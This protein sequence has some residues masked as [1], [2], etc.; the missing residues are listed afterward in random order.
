ML[1]RKNK[2]PLITALVL[3]TAL[4]ISW[5]AV[6]N[7]PEK[8]P[9]GLEPLNQ[10]VSNPELSTV[11]QT[12]EAPTASEPPEE[13]TAPAETTEPAPQPKPVEDDPDPIESTDPPPPATSP[14]PLSA[15]FDQDQEGQLVITTGVALEQIGVSADDPDSCQNFDLYQL[16]RV[17]PA[18]KLILALTPDQTWLCLAARDDGGQVSLTSYRVLPLTGLLKPGFVIRQTDDQ[19]LIEALDSETVDDYHYIITDNANCHGLLFRNNSG[20][21]IAEE[22][23]LTEADKNRHYCIRGQDEAG[24]HHY[25]HRYVNDHDDPDLAHLAQ[26]LQLTALGE[27]IFWAANPKLFHDPETFAATCSDRSSGCYIGRLYIRGPEIGLD[28]LDYG[29]FE[30]VGAHELSHAIWRQHLTAE[31]QQKIRQL[32]EDS[33]GHEEVFRN[34]YRFGEEYDSFIYDRITSETH[35]TVIQKAVELPTELDD[36]YRQFFKDP[37][38]IRNFDRLTKNRAEGLLTK[39]KRD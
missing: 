20:R 38:I 2:Y 9:A 37:L 35:S 31:G 13:Q 7:Q 1:A 11:D 28:D 25:E 21:P 23:P 4:S 10:P 29:W 5:L 36:H 19:L 32:I 15:R 39:D 18:T 14:S 30:S 12:K 22:T 3:A 34:H 26:R 6:A 16:E 27:E 8:Q 24:R 33:Y 17:Q